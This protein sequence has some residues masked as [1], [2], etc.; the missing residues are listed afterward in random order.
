MPNN[1]SGIVTAQ[2]VITGS[3]YQPGKPAEILVIN[4]QQEQTTPYRLIGDPLVQLATQPAGLDTVQL[5]WEVNDLIPYDARKYQ[6]VTAIFTPHGQEEFLKD[7]TFKILT[8]RDGKTFTQIAQT[9]GPTSS[10]L[11][12]GV[13]PNRLYYYKVQAFD[14]DG[15]LLAESPVTM[16][17]AGR[18]LV[19]QASFDKLPLAADDSD[20]KE[21]VSIVLGA[22]PYSD[23]QK[24][25]CLRPS[26]TRKQVEFRGNL[27]PI[28]ADKTYLQG[29][30]VRAP[31]NIWHGRY[32]YN[33]DRAHMSWG[34]S[35]PAVQ[36]TPEWTFGVQLLLPDKDGTGSRRKDGKPY[37]MAL[38]QWT[39]PTE[40]AYMSVFVIAYGPGQA[41]DFWIIEI[42]P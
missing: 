1:I 42:N 2:A 32:F 31:S 29:G 14:A 18:N 15:R 16:G 30:W 23:K 35:M 7:K 4:P 26:E 22:T 3:S 27:V 24:L 12:R 17:A 41:G 5:L 39:F 21:P 36:K 13:E 8:S 38:K 28:S 6:A 19:T 37:S 11:H 40:A 33:V 20:N 25:V 9:Q 34:Y 10:F